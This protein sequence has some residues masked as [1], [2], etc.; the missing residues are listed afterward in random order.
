MSKAFNPKILSN[1]DL[2]IIHNSSL[3]VLEEIGVKF[4]HEKILQLFKENGFKVD[5]DNKIVKMPKKI[6]EKIIDK[7][8]KNTRDL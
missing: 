1:K 8:I 4:P 2:E 6:V 7:T 3:I 5:N